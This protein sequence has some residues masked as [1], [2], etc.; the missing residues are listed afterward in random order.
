MKRSTTL[1]SLAVLLAASATWVYSGTSEPTPADTSPQPTAAEARLLGILDYNGAEDAL[2][3]P[4][5]V[6]A[7]E[8][9]PV[10]IT[11]YGGGCERK[12]DEGVVLG[13]NS[14]TVMVY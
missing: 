7:S 2:T 11:T 10:T 14:A 5:T 13:D 6:R 8:E 12:G 4:S 3:A 1:I 9:F